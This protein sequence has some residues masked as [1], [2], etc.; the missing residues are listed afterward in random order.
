[1]SGNFESE[2]TLRNALFAEIGEYANGT[3]DEV[4]SALLNRWNELQNAPQKPLDWLAI[5]LE[6][7]LHETP[8]NAESIELL[9]CAFLMDNDTVIHFGSEVFFEGMFP[10]FSQRIKFFCLCTGL[11]REVVVEWCTDSCLLRSNDFFDSE[12]RLEDYYQKALMGLTLL[13]HEVWG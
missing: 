7:V 1:M 3:S 5:R 11:S 9:L 12:L 6:G 13:D 4:K 10:I 8:L 2:S